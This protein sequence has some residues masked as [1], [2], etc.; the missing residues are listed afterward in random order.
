MGVVLPSVHNLMAFV[1]CFKFASSP[2]VRS[3]VKY[4]IEYPAEKK[5]GREKY[6]KDKRGRHVCTVRARMAIRDISTSSSV[7][8]LITD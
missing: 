7:R 1:L 3:L 6:K 5:R 4:I 2:F 8:D